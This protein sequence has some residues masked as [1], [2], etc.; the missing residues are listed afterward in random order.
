MAKIGVVLDMD[1]VISDTQKYHAQAEIELLGSYGIHTIEPNSDQIIT[2]ERISGNFAGVQP[3]DRMKTLFEIH[4][5]LDLFDVERIEDYKHEKLFELYKAGVPIVF[6]PW[7]KEFI[8][9]LYAAWIPMFVVTASTRDCMLF[10]LNTLG[11]AEMFENLVS[12]Y[13]TDPITLIPYVPKGEPDVYE[14][15]VSNYGLDYFVMIEDGSTGMN[16]AIKAWGKAIAILGDNPVSKFPQA[17]AHYRDL[18]DLHS[19]TIISFFA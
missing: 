13:D 9:D 12:I 18:T 16:G 1:G 19:D 11:V 4:G 10:V 2:T 6:I 8:D 3:K 7:A 17:V 14:R 15:I 5:K